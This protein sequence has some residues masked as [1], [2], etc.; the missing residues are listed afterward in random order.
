MNATRT[1]L[2]RAALVAGAVIAAALPRA[3][4]AQVFWT[5]WTDRAI[6]SPGSATG[7]IATTSGPVGVSYVGQVYTTSQ[8]GCGAGYWSV[9]PAIYRDPPAIPN[10]PADTG[11]PCDI[12]SLTGGP[13][14]PVN[15]VTFSRPILNPLMAIL[16]LGQPGVTITYNF[17]QPFD[18]LNSGRGWFGGAATGSL[19]QVTPDVLTGVEG[20][21]LIQ[22]TGTFSSISWTVPTA[23]TWHGFTLGIVN[24]AA[25]S[26][27]P[28]PTTTALLGLGLAGLAGRAVARR[29]RA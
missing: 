24:V 28:E 14:F 18:I 17:D 5:D 10:G 12:I 7:T 11:L 6:G 21:G 16:S 25:P 9:N 27:V 15:T 20:H 3:T 8:I 4:H 26:T 19:T 22:F 1:T 23:E 29:R 13:T 2:G